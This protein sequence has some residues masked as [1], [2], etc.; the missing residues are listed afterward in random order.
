MKLFDQSC[1]IEVF[2]DNPEEMVKYAIHKFGCCL[3]GLN[4]TEEWYHCSPSKDT[5]SDTASK[6]IGGHAVLCCGY[7]REGVI[8]QNSWGESFGEYGY[9]TIKWKAFLQQFQYGAVLS[10]ALNDLKLPNI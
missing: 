10:R 2:Y 8:I 1:E 7:N 4:I 3:L 5:I 6:F 9:V